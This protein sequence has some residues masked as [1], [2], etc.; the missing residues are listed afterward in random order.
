[1]GVYRL[2][3]SSLDYAEAL[4]LKGRATTLSS[5]QFLNLISY[6]FSG[7]FILKLFLL[8]LFSSAHY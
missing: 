6:G 3:G 8:H 5:L 7:P 4:L 2:Y 1:M